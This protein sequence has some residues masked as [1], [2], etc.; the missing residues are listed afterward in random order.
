MAKC[1]GGE[2][3]KLDL[4]PPCT[5]KEKNGQVSDCEKI[6]ICN[7]FFFNLKQHSYWFYSKE[8][9]KT[10]DKGVTS[11]SLSHLIFKEIVSCITVNDIINSFGAS[12]PPK[13]LRKCCIVSKMTQNNH[14]RSFLLFQIVRRVKEQ[15][16]VD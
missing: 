8:N 1:L 6:P 5:K 16:F 3:V 12:E 14:D 10:G 13:T 2:F 9:V 15:R 7:T 11:E 4:S